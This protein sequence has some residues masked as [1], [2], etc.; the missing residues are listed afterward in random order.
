MA[1]IG[2]SQ[3]Q[4]ALR[5]GVSNVAVHKAIQ[6]GRITPEADGS[7]I[8]AKADLQWEQMTDPAK[9]RFKEPP[10][11]MPLFDRD[12]QDEKPVTPEQLSAV[13][14]ALT[15]SGAGGLGAAGPMMAKARLANEL[16]KASMGEIKKKK[17]LGQLVDRAPAEAMVYELFRQERN[18]W[19]VWPT[20]VA[21]IMAAELRVEPHAMQTVLDR[22][23]KK[24]LAAMAQANIDFRTDK[25]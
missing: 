18:E 9:Q 17:A 24:Q 12:D 14:E 20:R 4:Y 23:I 22:H 21:A 7:I 10:Q 19:L 11:G 25:E 6:D 13:D 16:I 2:I 1:R 15:D 3:R 8:P 5:R